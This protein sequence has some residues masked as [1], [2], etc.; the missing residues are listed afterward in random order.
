MLP[1]EITAK[2]LADAFAQDFWALLE[3]LRSFG[4]DG[5]S[6]W[7][8]RDLPPAEPVAPVD[9]AAFLR[10][11]DDD[12]AWWWRPDGDVR[13]SEEMNAWLAQCRTALETL[14][15]EE[16][17]MHGTELLEL[18]IGTLDRIQR[19]NPSIFAFREMF[20]DFAARSES[21]MVQAAVRYLEQLAEQ[22]NAAVSLRRYLAVLGNFSLREKVFGF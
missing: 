9:T 21:P 17:V 20:Y 13:F 14:A 16:A 5:G 1:V 10:C 4:W 22:E 12:R 19:R 11:S 7:T 6:C 3:E 15:R 18:L 8:F 2:L